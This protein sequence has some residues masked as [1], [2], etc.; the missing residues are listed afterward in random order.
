MEL[1]ESCNVSALP[2]K[3]QAISAEHLALK[4]LCPF[5]ER[6]DTHAGALTH[7]HSAYMDTTLLDSQKMYQHQTKWSLHQVS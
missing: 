6:T 1:A 3:C 2:F 7:A 4:Q 5:N